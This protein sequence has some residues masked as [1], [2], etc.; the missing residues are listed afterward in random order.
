MILYPRYNFILLFGAADIVGS[1]DGDVWNEVAPSPTH[2]SQHII[3]IF[4]EVNNTDAFVFKKRKL[5]E[6]MNDGIDEDERA[7]DSSFVTREG[8][9]EGLH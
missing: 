8:E 1:T 2:L 9:Q 5:L 7:N 4:Y 6:P 3:H